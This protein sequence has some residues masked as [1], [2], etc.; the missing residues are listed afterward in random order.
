MLCLSDTATFAHANEALIF[1]DAVMPFLIALVFLALGWFSTR[2]I[3]AGRELPSH[4]KKALIYGFFF[5]LGTSYLM[6]FAGKLNWS[7]PVLFTAI[8]GWG[9]LLCSIAWRY[10][11]AE[12]PNSRVF[13]VLAEGLPALGLLMAVAGGAVEWEYILRGHGRWWVGLLWLIGVAAMIATAGR[14]RRI[15]IIVVLRGIVALLVIGAIAQRTSPAFIAA[16]VS[17]L[18][19]LILEKLWHVT[20]DNHGA[21]QRKS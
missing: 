6:L 19:L 2:A 10:R 20:S 3:Y 21:P 13:T 18:I 8:G 15:T 5:I 7:D 14:N 16:A 17:G 1:M 4:M 11:R 12:K 9:A